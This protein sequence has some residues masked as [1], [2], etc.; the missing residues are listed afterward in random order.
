MA[1]LH[2]HACLV[3]SLETSVEKFR[4]FLTHEAVDDRVTIAL[5]P[6]VLLPDI[7]AE[8]MLRRD[9]IVTMFVGPSCS[10]SWMPSDQGPFPRLTGE[11]ML[12]EDPPSRSRLVLM[13]D[14]DVQPSHNGHRFN[15]AIAKELLSHLARQIA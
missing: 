15:Q 10:V 8:V 6:T 13:G 7:G 14:M 12:V 3:E 2:R 11:L 5:R 4:R 1:N 9:V